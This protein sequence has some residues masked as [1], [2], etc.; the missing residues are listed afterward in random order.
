[1]E[2]KTESFPVV[3]FRSIYISVFYI[4]FY[5]HQYFIFI[6]HSGILV[7]EFLAEANSTN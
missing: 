3:K 5:A 4:L 6:L 7:L 2:L 1:M